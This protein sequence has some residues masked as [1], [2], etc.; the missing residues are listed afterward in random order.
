MRKHFLIFTVFALLFIACNKEE[1][2]NPV[3]EIELISVSHT[4]VESFNNDVSINIAYTDETGD[5]GYQ[6]PDTYSLRVKDSRLSEFDWYHIP[7]L[8]PNQEELNISGTFSLQL[9]PLF[10]LGNGDQESTSLSI[11]LKDRAGNWSNT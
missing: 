2:A 8:T 7:P 6:D 5:L 4:T 1:E 11:Q 10:L 9:N 3:P